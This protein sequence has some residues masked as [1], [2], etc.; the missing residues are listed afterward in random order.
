MEAKAK[1]TCQFSLLV[2]VFD[3]VLFNLEVHHQIL[4]I[5]NSRLGICGF[6]F[7]SAADRTGGFNTLE[8]FA[9][10]NFRPFNFPPAQKFH[11]FPNPEFTTPFLTIKTSGCMFALLVGVL[12]CCS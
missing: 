5:S 2:C 9:V 3:L 10:P 6:V 8:T 1:G 12:D 4:L 7:V 11:P